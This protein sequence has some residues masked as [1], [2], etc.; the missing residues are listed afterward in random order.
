MDYWKPRKEHICDICKKTISAGEVCY[1][2]EK[3]YLHTQCLDDLDGFLKN[4]SER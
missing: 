4:P 3:Y 1:K 2:E